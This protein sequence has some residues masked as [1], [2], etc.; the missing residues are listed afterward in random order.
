MPVLIGVQI[1]SHIRT[2]RVCI[3][4]W[5]AVITVKNLQIGIYLSWSSS[6]GG[7][8]GAAPSNKPLQV[9]L[10]VII[11]RF[12]NSLFDFNV[13]FYNIFLKPNFISSVYSLNDQTYI[14]LISGSYG[15]VVIL[16]V[17]HGEGPH[18][19]VLGSIYINSQH[20]CR[21]NEQIDMNY[22]R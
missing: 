12:L 19:I 14:S 5:Q 15:H 6:S 1:R 9:A 11:D 16:V 13:F 8:A 10:A 20:N 2:H 21:S 17:E 7:R 4:R 18:Q 3:L 22:K